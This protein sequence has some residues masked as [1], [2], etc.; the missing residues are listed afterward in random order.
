M[1]RHISRQ[2]DNELESV[3]SMFMNMGGLVESQLKAAV[4]AFSTKEID[5]LSEVHETEIQVDSLEREVEA[6]ITAVIAR[7]QPAASDLRLLVSLL[8]NCNDLERVGDE[9]VRIANVIQEI[10][11]RDIPPLIHGETLHLAEQVE[12]MLRDS[13]DS[14]ARLDADHAR[15]TIEMDLQID[16]GRDSLI[17]LCSDHIAGQT[18]RVEICLPLIWVA[19]SLERIGDHSEN[20]CDSV[21]YLVEGERV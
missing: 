8:K 2:F 20:V 19:R 14:L 10:Q 7:R 3:R 5:Q 9:S 17:Q 16:R 12:V 4:R 15:R 11:H 18:A 21:I 1:A 13:L 6:L